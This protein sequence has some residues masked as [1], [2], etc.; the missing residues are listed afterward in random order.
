MV[1]L[2]GSM[3]FIGLLRDAVTHCTC[4]D[5]PVAK[6]LTSSTYFIIFVKIDNSLPERYLAH[7]IVDPTS[8][9]LYAVEQKATVSYTK[10]C[11][12]QWLIL[13]T[14]NPDG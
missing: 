8:E 12:K 7:R 10:R 4:A 3:T 9:I 13:S 6:P 1:L 5:H 14:S 2:T 11:R